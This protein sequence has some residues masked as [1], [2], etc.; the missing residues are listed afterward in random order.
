MLLRPPWGPRSLDGVGQGIRDAPDSLYISL[1][2]R[3]VFGGGSSAVTMLAAATEARHW[4]DFRV[5]E[6]SRLVFVLYFSVFFRPEKTD[7]PRSVLK[8]KKLALDPGR[9]VLYCT[10][11]Y[12][13]IRGLKKTVRWLS[14]PFCTPTSIGQAHSSQQQAS[15]CVFFFLSMSHNEQKPS[16]LL[17]LLSLFVVCRIPQLNPLVVCVFF[18]VL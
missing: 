11:L 15:V 17:L 18:S 1:F 9:T 8:T 5:S 12:V 13:H 3:V 16:L 14:G 2:S 7:M 10:A 4:T 6:V